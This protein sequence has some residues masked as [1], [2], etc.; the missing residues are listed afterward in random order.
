[1]ATFLENPFLQLVINPALNSGGWSLNSVKDGASLVHGAQIGASY[2]IENRRVRAALPLDQ[3]EVHAG[4]TVPSPH[5]SLNM[6]QIRLGSK[7]NEL[8]YSLEFALPESKP[9]LLWRLKLSNKGQAPVLIDRLELF[10]GGRL[11][12]PAGG[13]A[14]SPDLAFLSNG[15]QSWS[16]SGVYGGRERQRRTRLWLLQEPPNTNPETPRTHRAGHFSSDMFAVLAERKSRAAVL[17]GFLSQRQHFG[18]LEAWADSSGFGL[19]MWAN[20]DLARLD[21]GAETSTDWACL[22]MVEPGAADPLG[23][24]VEAV[25]QEHN[26]EAHPRPSPTG[27]CSWYH[28]F[29]NIDPAAI[30]DNLQAVQEL[31][32]DLPL[33]LVQ[34][35][36]G[37]ETQVGDWLTFQPDFPDGVAPLAAEIRAAGLSPGLWLAPFIVHPKSKLR[38]AH[39]DWLLRGHLNRPVN[40]GYLWNTFTTALDLT[41]PDAQ[42]YV[43]EVIHTATQAWGFSYLKLDFLFAAALPG[44]RRDATRTRA[45]VLRA[46]LENVRM[47]AGAET[48]LLGCGCPLGPAL[49]LVDAMRISSDVDVGWLPSFRGKKPFLAAEPHMP[50]ARN[51]LQNVLCRA[52]LHS[53]W[54]IND[55]DCLLLRPETDLTLDEI[56]TL[57]SVIAMSGGSLFLSDHLPSLPPERL[58]IAKSLLPLIGQA[59][60]LPDWLDH[61][62]PRRL[63]LDLESCNGKWHLLALINWEDQA[64]DMAL[65]VAGYGLDPNQRYHAREFWRGLQGVI[66]DGR[67]HLGILPA[68]ATALCAVRLLADKTPQYLGSDLHISQGLEVDTWEVL[69]HGLRFS[70]QRP[71]QMQG[72]IWV[73]LPRQPEHAICN[74]APVQF[75]LSGEVF[76]F[77]LDAQETAAIQLDW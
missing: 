40:A 65:D 10:K 77:Q 22:A 68:H 21:S 14:A 15:W 70:I 55:P 33:D 63:R 59:P 6:L 74:G 57:A 35:D 69:A 64:Q 11:E 44:K 56:Q 60:R 36:D 43:R 39:P 51:A 9:M 5:G 41:H 27:W 30:R 13:Q 76:S 18:S 24:Y 3:A 48:I 29:Q 73:S 20:G 37:F 54:W 1:M 67:F 46:A 75:E 52:P 71:G 31:H 2:R 62:T 8:E 38:E 47:A 17:A 49:G 61:H 16:Y 72:K 45:Q 42:D 19:Q 58:R 28:F 12:L 4:E 32:T 66:E 53:R 7:Q 34:I 50:A 26:I 25:A 23:M